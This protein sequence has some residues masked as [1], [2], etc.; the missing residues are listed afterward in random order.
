VIRHSIRP[1][2]WEGLDCPISDEGKRHA[3]N[4]QWECDVAVVSPLCRTR[5]TLEASRVVAKQ[6]IETELCREY[7]GG[8]RPDY[9]E[10]DLLKTNGKLHVE[11]REEFAARLKQFR[12]FLADLATKH[13]S[14]LVV[15]HG[16]FMANLLQLQQGIHYCEFHPYNIP[17][18]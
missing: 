17:L 18:W 14:I 1:S 8:S 16:I 4:I 2:K 10:A 3:K 9:T 7:M 5:Q 13:K 15:T 11:T 12:D 6:V